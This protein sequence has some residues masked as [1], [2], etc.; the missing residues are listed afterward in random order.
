MKKSNLRYWTE[1]LAV[2]SGIACVLAV[3]F[4]TIGEATGNPPVDSAQGTPAQA[5]TTGSQTYEGVVTDTRCGAK[6]SAA[7]AEN[8]A[9]CTRACV[10]AGEHFALVNGDKLYILEGEPEL[11]K[12]SAGERVT[13]AGTLNG[14]TIAVNSVRSLT[15]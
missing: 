3:F 4:A 14:N 10:H 2:I 12:R 8:A 7:L 15:P 9:D 11:L 5:S 6:H 1:I 13:I